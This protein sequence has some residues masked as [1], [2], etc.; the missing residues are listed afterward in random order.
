ML[1]RYL[2]AI[3]TVCALLIAS[4]AG[5]VGYHVGVTRGI[6][7][8]VQIRDDNRVL[9]EACGVV[10]DQAERTAW[11]TE[12]AQETFRVVRAKRMEAMRDA[13]VSP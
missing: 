9:V 4:V 7:E 6:G 11:A 5:F 12:L 1:D 13:E 8:A 2:Y 3:I 10:L